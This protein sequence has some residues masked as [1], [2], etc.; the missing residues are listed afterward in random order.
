MNSWRKDE[1]RP[2]LRGLEQHVVDQL[3]KKEPKKVSF[4]GFVN[5]VEKRG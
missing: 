1:F 2:H 4:S 3:V 5:S